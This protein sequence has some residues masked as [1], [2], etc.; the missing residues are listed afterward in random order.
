MRRD[1]LVREINNGWIVK[2]DG[3]TMLDETTEEFFPTEIEAY[4]HLGK[5]VNED[6]QNVE[7]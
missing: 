4:T 7:A 6:L 3:G 2:R 5:L 1:Y